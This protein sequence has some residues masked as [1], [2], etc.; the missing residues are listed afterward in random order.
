MERAV[1]QRA[2][3]LIIASFAV[4]LLLVPLAGFVRFMLVLMAFSLCAF[5]WR[6]QEPA[7]T[8]RQQIEDTA[9]D[10]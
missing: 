9:S 8:S 2:V 10:G 3:L 7:E 6:I 4:T 5:I 1:K